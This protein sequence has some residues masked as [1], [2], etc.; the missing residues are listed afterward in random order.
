MAN[1]PLL[2]ESD[3]LVDDD[4]ILAG[5]PVSLDQ[6]DEDCDCVEED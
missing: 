2:T 3:E 1:E 6:R 4:T 5:R